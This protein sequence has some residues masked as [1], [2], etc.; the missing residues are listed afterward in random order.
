MLGRTADFAARDLKRKF[1]IRRYGGAQPAEELNKLI[2]LP[3]TAE[4]LITSRG[5]IASTAPPRNLEENHSDL[6][7]DTELAVEEWQAIHSAFGVLED[8]FG[9]D[10]APLG[11]EFGTGAA[12]PFGPALQYR[13]Y[14]VAGIWLN[15]FMGRIVADRAHPAMPPMALVAAGMAGRK[16]QNFAYEIGR[17]T[18]GISPD[19]TQATKVNPTLAAALIESC[20][21]L[22]VAGIQVEIS[23]NLPPSNLILIL[24]RE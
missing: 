18:A 22:F 14:G 15:F 24:T 1:A 16:T 13:T 20:L 4:L 12:T 7:A 2:K 19:L 9:R 3:P 6:Q 23:R 21:A 5:F 17:I 10:F 11:P 8:R